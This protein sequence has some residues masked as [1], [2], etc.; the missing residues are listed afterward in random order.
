MLYS[1]NNNSTKNS[2]SNNTSSINDTPDFFKSFI[3][4]DISLLSSINAREGNSSDLIEEHFFCKKCYK[5]PIIKFKSFSKIYYSCDC[6]KCNVIHIKNIEEMYEKKN[7]DEIKQYLFC[8]KHKIEFNYY[9]YTCSTN[10][11]RN[12]LRLSNTHSLHNFFLFDTN[13]YETLQKINNIKNIL[14]ENFEDQDLLEILNSSLLSEEIKDN[15]INNYIKPFFNIIFNDFR[16]YPNYSHF[17]I[18]NNFNEFL[19]RF[20]NNKI[21]EK[22]IEELDLNISFNITNKNDLNKYKNNCEKILSICLNESNINDITEICE[23]NL[24]NLEK[25]ELRNNNIS[26]I[27]PL[28]KAKF[29]NIKE[30]NFGL[31]NIDDTN[32]Q[33]L[34]KIDFP[35]LRILNLYENHFQSIDIFKIKNNNKN[36]SNLK[37]FYIGYNHFS[38]DINKIDT[39]NINFDFSSLDLIGLTR[40]FNDNSI[41]LIKYFLFD[42]LTT[43]Y[44]SYSNISSLSFLNELELPKIKNFQI[45]SSKISDYYPLVKYKTLEKIVLKNNKISNINNLIEFVEELPNLKHLELQGNDIDSNDIKN[46]EIINKVRSKNI[47][48]ITMK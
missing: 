42:N 11:C 19:N 48:L 33:Y 37:E 23:L 34:Y 7:E 41:K 38:F 15:I 1:S 9:C 2:S 44:L 5:V 27:E 22:E 47:N 3:I 10:L 28:L 46:N 6:K 30:I 31:N 14:R 32:V 26:N 12:C 25:L 8:N 35:N 39:K 16:A 36:L 43:L 24:V 4:Q 40:D 29:K 20:L 21:N 45:H 13:I 17:E 18:I